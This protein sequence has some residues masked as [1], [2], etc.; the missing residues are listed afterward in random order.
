MALKDSHIDKLLDLLHGQQKGGGGSNGKGGSNP[1]ADLIAGAGKAVNNAGDF[2]NKNILQPAAK[3]AVN[4]INPIGKAVGQQQIL[5]GLK[6]SPTISSADQ[7]ISSL[8]GNQES[9]VLQGKMDPNNAGP[10]LLAGLTML[11]GKGD[12]EA[13]VNTDETVTQAQKDRI[14]ADPKGNPTGKSPV[15]VQNTDLYKQYGVKT[16]ARKTEVQQTLDKEVPGSTPSEVASNLDPTIAKLGQQIDERTAGNPSTASKAH[17]NGV[18]YQDLADSMMQSAQ[19]DGLL[20]NPEV[21]P[22]VK[23]AISQQINYIASKGANTDIAANT[24]IFDDNLKP[25]GLHPVTGDILAEKP[26]DMDTLRNEYLQQNADHKNILSKISP[27]RGLT[28]TD[29]AQL[30]YRNV[31]KDK[32]AATDPEVSKLIQKQHD[33]Y[34]ASDSVFGAES[35]QLKN[36]QASSQEKA[37][38]GNPVKGFLF[39]NP[40]T[41]PHTAAGI[42]GILTTLGAATQIPNVVGALTPSKAGTGSFPQAPDTTNIENKTPVTIPNTSDVY[43][44]GVYPYQLKQAQSKVASDAI[45]LKNDPYNPTLQKAYQNDQ[46]IVDSYQ[47]KINIDLANWNKQ[48]PQDDKMVDNYLSRDKQ[49]IDD[50]Q[51]SLKSG[52][53]AD[54]GAGALIN[55]LTNDD[56]LANKNPQYANLRS[57]VKVL[58]QDGIISQGDIHRAMTSSS[59]AAQLSAKLKAYYSKLQQVMPNYRTTPDYNPPPSGKDIINSQLQGALNPAPTSAAPTPSPTPDLF[60]KLLQYSARG[61]LYQGQ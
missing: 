8:G 39:G 56:I 59:A 32:I 50:V 7:F 10:S 24:P 16:P 27:T 53:L 55:S 30:L 1:I 47:S 21:K 43:Q 41:L 3:D 29:K 46:N 37:S 6:G 18:T 40:A 61:Q 33:L 25:V 13:D 9:P 36:E 12:P 45:A 38:K 58:E 48:H 31:L 5:P 57:Q 34:D 2:I 49:A 42:G 19:D 52:A 17:P 20:K 26:L 15:Q 23:K 14:A 54:S 22:T 11:A 4:V 35:A 51:S 44:Q 60:Q 28:V